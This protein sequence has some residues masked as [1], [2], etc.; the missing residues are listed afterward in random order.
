M[1]CIKIA[2]A[3]VCLATE[4]QIMCASVTDKSLSV[5]YH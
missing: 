2:K 1:Q 5:F 4:M 3:W